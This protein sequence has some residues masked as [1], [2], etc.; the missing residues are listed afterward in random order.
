VLNVNMWGLFWPFGRDHEP[1][2]LAL[3]QILQQ[4]SFD[5]VLLQ[6]V[7]LKK[8]YNTIRD[9]M[10]YASHFEA[11]NGCTG[12]ELFPHEC[13]GLVV[14]SR[15]PIEYVEFLPFVDRGSVMNFDGEVF[16]RKGLASARI[17]WHDLTVDVFTSHF[18][19][20]RDDPNTNLQVRQ[21]QTLQTLNA[22]IHS[23]ADIKVF[24]GDTNALPNTR[25]P[26]S[27]YSML[28]S[29]MRDV[30]TDRYPGAGHHPMFNTYGNARNSYTGGSSHA[31]RIDYLMYTSRPGLRTRTK[32]FIM[33]GFMTRNV[34]GRQVS[35]ADHEPLLAE[36]A[37]ESG[38]AVAAAAMRPVYS[39]FPRS[40]P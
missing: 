32:E 24:G 2:F 14:L 40:A 27:P 39:Y 1:R 3:R 37:V 13:S 28:T 17:R 5:I 19:S 38:Q 7:W 4:G 26:T 21:S 23:D 36:I 18:A 22:I 25:S 33:P 6:E 11:Y 35:I 30:L 12:N 9:S 34:D 8:Q 15:H 31:G 10:P 20:Y 16:A 29:A